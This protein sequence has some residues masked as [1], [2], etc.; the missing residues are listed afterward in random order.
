[1]VELDLVGSPILVA[2]MVI[3]PAAVGVNMLPFQVPLPPPL[4]DHVTPVLKAPVTA[5][6]YVTGV[7][8]ET[9]VEE[10]VGV[11]TATVWGV[12]VID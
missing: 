11:P 10:G 4:L 12:R 9:V 1:M 6:E 3:D 2:V 8:V 5:A 7:L